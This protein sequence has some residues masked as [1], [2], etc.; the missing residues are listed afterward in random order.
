MLEDFPVHIRNKSAE[1]KMH[2]VQTNDIKH[3]NPQG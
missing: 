1:M 2:K 3:Y